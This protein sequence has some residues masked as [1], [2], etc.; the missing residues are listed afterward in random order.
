[1]LLSFIQGISGYFKSHPTPPAPAPAGEPVQI[2]EKT[3]VA[4][5]LSLNELSAASIEPEL[6]NPNDL[7]SEIT[8]RL[9][10]Q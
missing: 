5:E 9:Q 2:E 7:H 1:V 8:E 3:P 4:P 10:N 6:T